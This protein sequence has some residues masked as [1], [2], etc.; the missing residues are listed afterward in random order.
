METPSLL[1]QDTI[2]VEENSQELDQSTNSATGG[3]DQLS[4]RPL[5]QMDSISDCS[6][7]FGDL[8]NPGDKIF[9]TTQNSPKGVKIDENEKTMNFASTFY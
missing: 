6:F 7:D 9:G 2:P 8:L 3:L 5:P 1:V 4:S